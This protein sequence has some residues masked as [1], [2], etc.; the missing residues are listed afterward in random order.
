MASTDADDVFQTQR[1][2]ANQ[3]RRTYL[4]TYSQADLEKV[5]T[6]ERFAD[7]VVDAFLEGGEK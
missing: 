2:T 1:L 7:L 4:V 5:P 3:A 6:R